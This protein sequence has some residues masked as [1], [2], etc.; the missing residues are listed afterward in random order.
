M[1]AVSDAFEQEYM[2]DG[3]AVRHRDKRV[4]R[5]MAAILAVPA[6]FTL[7]LTFIIGFGN[8]GADRP[9]PDV[10][11]PF[12]LA[13]LVAFAMMFALLSLTFAV[14][15]TIVTEREVIVRYG[16][17]GPSIALEHITS[18]RVVDYEW[19]KFG[20]WGIRR[21]VGGTWA[22]VP[23]PGQVV[24]LRYDDGSGERTV[25][26]GAFEA[27][28]LAHAIDRARE[29]QT[30]VRVGESAED[31]SAEAEAEAE[32]VAEAERERHE[33]RRARSER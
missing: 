31:E 9:L 13:G 6:L 16:L 23:G 33:R 12:V 25:Q 10:A 14:L 5:G 28:S 11:L 17:W 21:G 1:F 7:F 15:R 27:H 29:A 8:A 18:C 22:Y 19:T 24:E 3:S 26:I 30:R 32:A 4:S 2:A 20:G